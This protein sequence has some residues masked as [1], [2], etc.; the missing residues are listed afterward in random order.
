M[1]RKITP[2][3]SLTLISSSLQTKKERKIVILKCKTVRIAQN[4][5][6]QKDSVQKT[7]KKHT[8]IV[9]GKLWHRC[10]LK[11]E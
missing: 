4:M 8:R 5:K 2:N 10:I 7:N 9:G 6:S 3:T 1:R 11:T